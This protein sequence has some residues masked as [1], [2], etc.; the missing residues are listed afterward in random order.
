MTEVDVLIVGA[1]ISGIGGAVHLKQKCPDKSFVILEGRERLGGTWD[2]FKYPGIR[3]DSDMYT[4][5][6]EFKPW[7]NNKAIAEAP[8]ILKYLN[9]TVDE[10]GLRPNLKFEARVVDLS[11]SSETQRWTVTTENGPN[12]NRE[13]ISAGFVFMGTGYYSYSDPYKPDFPEQESFKG[14]IIHPQQWPEG[15]DYKGKKVVIIGSGATAVTIVPAMVDTGS[16]HVTML[17]RSPGYIFSGP[18]EDNLAIAFNKYLPGKMAYALTRWRKIAMQWVSYNVA[19]KRP[20]KVKQ[21]LFA[22]AEQEMGDEYRRLKKDLEPSYGPWDQRLCL[23]PDG[24]LFR[25]IREKQADI[26]TG[27][28]ARFTPMGIELKD[29]RTI[30]ADIIITATGLKMEIMSGVSMSVDGRAV[31]LADTISYKGFMYSDVPN[32]VSSFGYSNASWTLKSD[33]IGKYMCRLLKHMDA[34]KLGSATP[35]DDTVVA[36]PESLMNL[37]AGYVDRAL[38]TLPK[39]GNREPWR[40][41]HNYF[42]DRWNL[43]R[44]PIDTDMVFAPRKTNAAIAPQP[45]QEFAEA[46]E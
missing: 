34:N 46:A 5:G 39:Q 21:K 28:I 4:L 40:S 38:A 8:T 20:E 13:T 37:S 7:T 33:L 11:W 10:F 44:G 41:H 29:G 30:E 18:S 36:Q 9:E 27:H 26:V 19:Q 32:L 3:S 17:Q 15:L 22:Q 2:L 42:L 24:D 14:P 1:G 35:H 16:G 23:I 6:F 12:K 25:V 43:S 45:V 31:K